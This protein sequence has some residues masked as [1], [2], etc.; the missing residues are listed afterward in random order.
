[1]LGARC[2]SWHLDGPEEMKAVPSGVI[3]TEMTFKA[4]TRLPSSRSRDTEAQPAPGCQG[5]ERGEARRARGE[6]GGSVHQDPGPECGRAGADCTEQEGGSGHPDPIPE[7]RGQT[8]LQRAASM[9]MSSPL[10]RD[11]FINHHQHSENATCRIRENLTWVEHPQHIKN[12]Y[13]SIIQNQITQKNWQ[14]T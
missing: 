2:L 3:N 12:S 11:H 14:R 6:G 8:A 9:A 10:W 1:M 7:Q 4:T 5:Q 13:N